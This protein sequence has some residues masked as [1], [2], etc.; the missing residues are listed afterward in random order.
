[1][2]GSLKG[3]GLKNEIRCDLNTRMLASNFFDFEYIDHYEF[4][5]KSISIPTFK[6]L[7]PQEK[8]NLAARG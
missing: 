2:M 3:F 6:P 1:M 8:F 5:G 7:D 4:K